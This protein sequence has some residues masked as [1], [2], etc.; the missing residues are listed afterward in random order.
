MTQLSFTSSRR[1]LW[2]RWKQSGSLEVKLFCVYLVMISFG[3]SLP[4][5]SADNEN[6]AVDSIFNMTLEELM[7]VQVDVPAALTQLTLLEIPAAITSITAEDIRLTPARNIYDLIEFY[8]PGAIWMN[9]ES[10]PHPGVRGNIVNR[11]YKFLLLVNGR[12]MNNKAY[13]GASSELEMWDMGDIERIDI[14]RGPGSVTY[15]PGAVAGVISITTRRAVENSTQVSIKQVSDYDSR[16]VTLDH[17]YQR[18]DYQLF[19]HASVVRTYGDD[20]LNFQVT[21]RN[22]AGFVGRDIL[23]DSE[24]MDYFADYQGEPQVKLHMEMNMGEA[25]TWWTRYTQQGSNWRGNEIKSDF[26]GDLLNQQ[27][28]RTRQIT[29]QVEHHTALNKTFNLMTQVSVDSYDMERRIEAVRD[30]EPDHPLNYQVNFAEDEL[31]LRSV[32]NQEQ[33]DWGQFALGVEWG[34]DWFGSGWGDDERAMRLGES[35]EIVSGADS[36]AIRTGNGGSADRLGNE[37][38]VG[39]GWETNSYAIFGESSWVLSPAN[40]LLVSARYDK[41]TYTDWL[42]S[43]RLAWLATIKEGHVVK[44][45]AQRSLRINTAAQLYSNAQFDQKSTPEKFDGLEL[46]YTLQTSRVSAMNF[47]LFRNDSEVIA[48]QG[49]DNSIRLVGDL[50]LW[51]AEAEWRYDASWGTFG[52]NFSYVKQIDWHLAPGIQSSGISYSDYT[53]PIGGANTQEGFGNDLNNWPTSSIKAFTHYKFTDDLTIHLDAHWFSAWQ[54]A[55]DGLESLRRA[56]AGTNNEAAVEES[57][58]RVAAE[59]TYD[60]DFRLNLLLEYT[61]PKAF[62]LQIFSQNLLGRHGNKRYSYDDAGNN[63]AAPRRVRFTEEPQTYG[64]RLSHS[65]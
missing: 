8:V 64:L 2:S 58:A 53:L 63:Q 30:P 6:Q 44:L 23:L 50:K 9:H 19:A 51:G 45:I 48:F 25:W 42:F 4:A 36:W 52:T 47:S 65:F 1:S 17:S 21:R 11:N 3:V 7:M 43:P 18:D 55:K 29:S 38:F 20:A 49:Q 61:M 5:R 59:D 54:G 15:G 12:V 14:V 31:I 41:N 22:E 40:K 10:G 56:V 34:R 24:A 46:I 27:G 28:L 60:S 13:A 33:Q 35:G 37:L 16:G 26:S 32:L 39:K 57:L 62:T